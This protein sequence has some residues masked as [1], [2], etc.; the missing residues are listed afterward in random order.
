MHALRRRLAVVVAI[1]AM[2]LVAAVTP[3]SA[4][5]QDISFAVVGGSITIGAGDDQLE[6][7]FPDGTGVTGTWDDVTGAVDA[8][9]V[10]PVID[11]DYEFT[12]GVLIPL[13]ITITQNGP[14]TGS[15]DPQTGAGELALSLSVGVG[16]SALAIPPGCTVGPVDLAFSTDEPGVPMDFDA[17]TLTLAAAQFEIP[18][19]TGC[20]GLTALINDG[21]GLPRSDTAAVAVLQQ[22]GIEAP[23]PTTEAPAPPPPP[24]APV[25][26]AWHLPGGSINPTYTCAGADAATQT[27]LDVLGDEALS[28]APTLAMAPIAPSPNQGEQFTASFTGGLNLD[29]E[30]VDSVLAV[31]VTEATV[32][33]LAIPVIPIDGVSGETFVMRP[34]DQS[35]TLSPGQPLS[36]TVG[37]FDATFTRT[38]AIGERIAFEVGELTVTLG[39]TL[40]G[41]PV[42]LHLACQPSGDMVLSMVDVQGATAPAGI[43]PVT[44]SSTTTDPVLVG[45]GL[46]LLGVGLVGAQERLSRRPRPKHAA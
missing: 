28:F 8:T 23:P 14:A 5:P 15:I 26:A 31:G 43:L 10:V 33:N 6:I 2:S 27:L 22:G 25:D 24:A 17:G 35:F 38:S 36:M 42:E 20:N 18:E 45:A 37:P 39:A 46:L 40:G 12:E 4:A 21:L 13:T 9:L 19:A 41:S 44:G 29:S 34:P 32:S 11:V 7:E 1:T 3:S 30:L 16:S